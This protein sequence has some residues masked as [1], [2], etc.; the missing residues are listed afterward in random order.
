MT[1]RML[2]TVARWNDCLNSTLSTDETFESTTFAWSQRLSLGLR[3][4]VLIPMVST[5]GSP[6]YRQIYWKSSPT[7][8]S[9]LFNKLK[10]GKLNGGRNGTQNNGMVFVPVHCPLLSGSRSDLLG[11][12]KQSP[13]SST[14]SSPRFRNGLRLTPRLPGALPAMKPASDRSSSDF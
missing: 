9:K 6:R 14:T 3:L 7:V 11:R 13:H 2:K 4:P 5:P 1:G 10:R 8:V 12:F